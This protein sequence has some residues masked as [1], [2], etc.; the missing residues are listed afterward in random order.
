MTITRAQL[1]AGLIDFSDIDMPG[2]PRMDPL[3]P[4]QVLADWIDEER[5]TA[6][7]LAAAVHLPMEGV[8]AVLSGD[9][10]ITAP[11]ALRL[12]RYFGT[13]ARFWLNL[14]MGYELEL[15]ERNESEVIAREITPRAA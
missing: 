10:P 2:S 5:M 6:A 8:A 1:D 4:G 12:A 9:A 14:Q 13:S 7:D 15:A 11:L 3:H